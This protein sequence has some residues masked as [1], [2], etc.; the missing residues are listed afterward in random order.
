MPLKEKWFSGL[1]PSRVEGDVF[2]NRVLVKNPGF[3]KVRVEIPFDF[4]DLF[5][6]FFPVN[7]V[8]PTNFDPVS[9]DSVW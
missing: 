5:W 9:S 2:T 6:E 1:S 7:S 4:R 3:R 8:V